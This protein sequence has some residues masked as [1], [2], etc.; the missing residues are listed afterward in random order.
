[1]ST[2]TRLILILTVVVGVVMGA[3]GYLLV[4]R[5]ESTLMA[6]RRN[7]VLAHAITLQIALDNDFR[8]GRT[9]DAKVLIDRLSENPKIE[10]V[11]LYDENGDVSTLSDPL[12]EAEIHH[13]AEVVRVI[14]SGATTE[15][16]RNIGGTEFFSVIMPLDFVD[17]RRGAF[18]I[19][20]VLT[21]VKADIAQARVNIALTT[22]LL[23]MTIIGA[24]FLVTRRSISRPIEALLAGARA[25][26]RGDFGHR[27]SVPT[28]NNE[29]AQ[30]ASE[31][32]R[33]ADRLDEQRRA[34]SRESE[35]RLTIERE[36][37]HGERLALVG[38]LAAGVAHEMG[39]PLNVIDGR[40]EQILSR[41]DMP[42]EGRQRNL[43]I[44]RTQT[45]RIAG[46][47]RQLL[48]L[49]RPYH[50]RREAVDLG[51]AAAGACDLVETE[52]TAAGVTVELAAGEPVY[53]DADANLL[54]QVLL[55]VCLN[56]VQAMHD[57]GRLRVEVLPE[58]G[59]AYAAVRVSDTGPGIAPEHLSHVFEPFF[60]KKD[61]GH[62]TGLGLTVSRRIVEEHG[63]RIEASNAEGGGAIFT[64]YIPRTVAASAG[65]SAENAKDH[66]GTVAH[67]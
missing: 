28:R 15:R 4:R 40:A 14:E 44:I 1:M 31:F 46:I 20:E 8:V 59:A 39:A 11:I 43:T 16:L 30:L 45:K 63:G 2:S 12:V 47:V 18:E 50:L 13:S 25:L 62:G 9:E 7:E 6:H 49:A 41:P 29:F 52:A 55:N 60:T 17:G 53:V 27:V 42:L 48:D 21:F 57:G 67:R 65:A 10:G 66:E 38:R 61:V 37:R 35:E 54:Q 64:I 3:A 24:V 22:L 19:I 23:Y 26:G 5:Q 33:M 36:L 34:A 56:G 32:N 51:G 58:A